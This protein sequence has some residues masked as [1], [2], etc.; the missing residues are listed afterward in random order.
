MLDPLR[1]IYIVSKRRALS[2]RDCEIRDLPDL[3]LLFINYIYKDSGEI[4][5][6]DSWAAIVSAILP[7]LNKQ[8]APAPVP[9]GKPDT[10]VGKTVSVPATDD[11]VKLARSLSGL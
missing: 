10:L 2:A 5:D 7:E 1:R 3:D 11:L 9:Q 4:R 6:F 8:S